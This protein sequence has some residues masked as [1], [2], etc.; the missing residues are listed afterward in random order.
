MSLLGKIG[1]SYLS[2]KPPYRERGAA[3][4]PRD[5][6][7][8]EDSAPGL[9]LNAAYG[10]TIPAVSARQNAPYGDKIPEGVRNFELA[11]HF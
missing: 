5:G 1:N 3:Q 9:I 11:V 8:Y 7:L 2:I 10:D 4:S 6:A